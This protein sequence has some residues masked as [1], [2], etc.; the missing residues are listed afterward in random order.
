MPVLPA[1]GECRPA[2]GPCLCGPP[3]GAQP[4][5]AG[6]RLS[7]GSDQDV[8]AFLMFLL[9]VI[10]IIHGLWVHNP[11]HM[12]CVCDC[13]CVQVE[14]LKVGGADVASLEKA[15]TATGLRYDVIVAADQDHDAQVGPSFSGSWD[16]LEG[17]R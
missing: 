10:E 7:L 1:G 5:R 9:R 13:A 2:A 15:I 11:A 16:G 14:A 4:T 8:H 12:S 6:A 17:G 3:A